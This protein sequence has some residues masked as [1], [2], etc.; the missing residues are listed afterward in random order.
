MKAMRLHLWNKTSKSEKTE[1]TPPNTHRHAMDIHKH[2][3]THISAMDFVILA[4]HP[5]MLTHCISNN[6][7]K[8]NQAEMLILRGFLF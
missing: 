7:P 1:H 2:V 8:T 3:H 6:E 4:C 5:K